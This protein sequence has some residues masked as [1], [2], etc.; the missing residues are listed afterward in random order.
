MDLSVQKCVLN[1]LGGPVINYGDIR[2][3][4]YLSNRS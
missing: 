1:T 2:M 3:F 4:E